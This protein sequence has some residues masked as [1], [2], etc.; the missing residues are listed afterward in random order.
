MEPHGVL[1]DDF[2]MTEEDQIALSNLAIPLDVEQ[3]LRPTSGIPP[4]S[5]V[6][7]SPLAPCLQNHDM[8]NQ[9]L[10][11]STQSLVMDNPATCQ[12]DHAAPS[13]P[14]DSYVQHGVI[15][16]NAVMEDT[17][18]SVDFHAAQLPSWS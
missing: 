10:T 4:S 2:D 7:S 12:Y 17:E 3:G 9:E 11:Q 6:A 1:S 8:V 16:D 13:G 18:T 5:Q 14:M 15:Q